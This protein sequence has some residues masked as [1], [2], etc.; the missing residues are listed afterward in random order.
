MNDVVTKITDTVKNINSNALPVKTS[1][2]SSFNMPKATYGMPKATFGMPKATTYGMP[3]ATYGMSNATSAT[4]TT[5]NIDGWS[6]MY[7]L[8]IILIIIILALLGFNI[9]AYM[10]R[11]TDIFSNF[12]KHHGTY[13]PQGIKN[14]MGITEKGTKL[15][16]DVA[17]DTI[18]D[19]KNIMEKSTGIHEKTWRARDK[20]LEQSINK[21][22]MSGLNKFPDH[23]PDATDSQIQESGKKGWC[24]VGTDR[25]F[26]SCIKVN[27]SEKCMSGKIFPTKDICINPSLRE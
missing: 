3:K 22:N 21:G 1:P 25:T 26:R 20:N 14:I 18:D 4:V 9:F 15:G 17:A 6:T 11:G 7:I 8:K 10:A 23:E 27:E 19:A 24:Y 2:M 13:I 5:S 16:L 12:I